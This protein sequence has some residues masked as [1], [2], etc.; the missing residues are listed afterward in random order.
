MGLEFCQISFELK[1]GL[2]SCQISWIK[3]GPRVLPDVSNITL[4]CVLHG[5]AG[6]ICILDFGLMTDVTPEQSIALVEYIAHLSAKDWE[7]VTRDLVT[8]GF[9]PE[10]THPLVTLISLGSIPDGI[11]YHG[12]CDLPWPRP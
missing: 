9:I 4:R 6:K 12:H 3:D 5:L 7:A 11:C 10:G 1:M 2:E 8:L